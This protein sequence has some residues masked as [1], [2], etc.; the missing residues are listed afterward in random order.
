MKG[1]RTDKETSEQI[2]LG[3][4]LNAS[5]NICVS[6]KCVRVVIFLHDAVCHLKLLYYILHTCAAI[7]SC[8]SSI[9]CEIL[10]CERLPVYLCLT[11]AL[12][13]LATLL[14]QP[15]LLVS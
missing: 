10:R 5:F 6:N 15:G 8:V 14:L 13:L 9:H 11:Q 12:S 3:P 2:P 4:V 1:R 7:F